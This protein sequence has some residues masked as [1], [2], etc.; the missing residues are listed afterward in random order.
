MDAVHF[1]DKSFGE[2]FPEYKRW[3]QFRTSE[4]VGRRS[5]GVCDSLIMLPLITC[6]ACAT[7][8]G[9]AGLQVTVE[10]G[11]QEEDQVAA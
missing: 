9:C 8:F 6:T 5:A 7:C 2:R 11:P 3:L 4:M 1:S 10:A